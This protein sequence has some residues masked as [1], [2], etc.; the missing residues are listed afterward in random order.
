MCLSVIETE[1]RKKSKRGVKGASLNGL[2]RVVLIEKVIFTPRLPRV[3]GVNP[4]AFW[5]ESILDR[6]SSQCEER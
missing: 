1:R 6:G 3:E 5:A 2:Y 4:V